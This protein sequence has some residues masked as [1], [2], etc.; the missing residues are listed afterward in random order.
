MKS[1]SMIGKP[2]IPDIIPVQ[3]QQ[4][5]RRAGVGRR[6]GCGRKPALLVVDMCR[7]TTD[8]V[9]PLSCPETARPAAANIARLLKAVRATEMPVIFT[10]QRTT[11]PYSAATGG[12]LIDKAIPL[13]SDFACDQAPHDIVDEVRPLAGE[14]VLVKP[15]PSAFF[16]TQLASILLFHGVDTL[17]VTGT[18]TSGCIRAT[19]D[20]AAAYNFRVI[21]PHECV[22]DRFQLSHQ[23]AL[24][25]MDAFLADV[26][27]LDELL[28]YVTRLDAAPHMP[29]G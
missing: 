9:Y 15:K 27:G 17:I 13:S 18:T 28:A 26:I 23:V 8:P 5:H 7:Y 21:V 24:F 14:T 6:M 20:H 2:Y 11:E 4:T 10:T 3:D 19:V 29:R 25:D 1:D 22:A 16:G 12:R